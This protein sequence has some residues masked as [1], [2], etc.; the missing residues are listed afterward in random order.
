MGCKMENE[1]EIFVYKEDKEIFVYM[2]DQENLEQNINGIKRYCVNNYYNFN[3]DN[4]F[5]DNLKELKKHIH[6]GDVLILGELYMLGSNIDEIKRELFSFAEKNITL[7]I[8]KISKALSEYLNNKNELILD[9]LELL[10]KLIYLDA[11]D[12]AIEDIKTE[13]PKIEFTDNLVEKY[14]ESLN[15]EVKKESMEFTKKLEPINIIDEQ[16]DNKSI[17]NEE[18]KRFTYPNN[19]VIKGFNVY[20]T[21]NIGNKIS[22]KQILKVGTRITILSIDF[23]TQLVS[24]EYLS[25]NKVKKGFIKNNYRCIEYLNESNY[26]NGYICTQ[27]YKENDKLEK[28][29]VLYPYEKATI[30]YKEN[31]KLCI[32]YDTSRGRN[33]KAGFI[34]PTKNKKRFTYA[35]NAVIHNFKVALRDERGKRVSNKVFL[36]VGKRITVLWI[37]VE[38]QLALIEYL[39]NNEIRVGYIKNSGRTIKYLNEYAYE[40]TNKTTLTYAI[41]NGKKHYIGSLVPNE[42]F[43]VL[44]KDRFGT[45]IIYDTKEGKNSKSAFIDLDF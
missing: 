5:I 6:S 41:Y 20:L 42:K 28:Y 36:N 8:L 3:E 9:E 37:N 13:L 18:L 25:E 4:I 1:I 45:Y 23:E 40:N 44:Y 27:V 33:S 19:A 21:D 11:E 7:V 32:V 35:N 15:G 43:T 24:I 39:F 29:G 17:I 34:L 16:I 10:E 22:N 31:S 2:C 30:L 14:E 12:K 26:T 38:K